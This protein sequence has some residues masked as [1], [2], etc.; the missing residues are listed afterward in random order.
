MFTYIL[1]L[2]NE[3]QSLSAILMDDAYYRLILDCRALSGDLPIVTAAGLI[4]LKARAWLDLMHRRKEGVTSD[5]SDIRKHR[6]DVFRLTAT[7]PAG[8]GPEI[9]ESVRNDLRQFVSAF[10]LDSAEWG[11]LLKSLKVDFGAAV[12]RPQDLLTTLNTYF[13]LG[14]S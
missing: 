6:R 14:M 10:A 12:P 4:P 8:A 1:K 9:A 11:D 13:E 3:L 5:D 7:L 2:D